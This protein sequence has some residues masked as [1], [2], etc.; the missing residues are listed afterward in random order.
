MPLEEGGTTHALAR[1]AEPGVNFQ[2]FAL[3]QHTLWPMQPSIKQQPSTAKV[4]LQQVP[5]TAQLTSFSVGAIRLQDKDLRG[6]TGRSVGIR[7]RGGSN[8]RGSCCSSRRSCR[9]LAAVASGSAG[10]LGRGTGGGHPGVLGG[11]PEVGWHEGCAEMY[12]ICVKA[13]ISHQSADMHA[14]VRLLSPSAAGCSQLVHGTGHANS[15]WAS[16]G[17]SKDPAIPDTQLPA[18]AGCS[19]LQLYMR[20]P[21]ST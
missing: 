20:S 7:S 16:M 18:L 2:S 1:Q 15:R 14:C 10:V 11:V 12:S 4:L 3:V 21:P 8:C 17:A 13:C 5:F 19:Q 6:G 9:R